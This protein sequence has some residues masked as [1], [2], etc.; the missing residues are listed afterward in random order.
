MGIDFGLPSFASGFRERWLYVDVGVTSPLLGHPTL[1]AIP[2]PD[3]GHEELMSPQ[4]AFGWHRFERLRTHGV[5]A[6]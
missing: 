2:N 5:T 1:P 4:L 6:P 3:W